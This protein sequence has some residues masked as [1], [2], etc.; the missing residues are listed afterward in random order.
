MG[1]DLP[2]VS[3]T[4]IVILLMPLTCGRCTRCGPRL[5]FDSGV[6][7]GAS[8]NCRDMCV[9]ITIKSDVNS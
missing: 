6:L 1:I 2:R 3:R 8:V 9:P 4:E 7:S 5:G